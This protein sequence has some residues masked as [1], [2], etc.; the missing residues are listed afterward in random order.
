[1]RERETKVIKERDTK[2]QMVEK[3]KGDIS[4]NESLLAVSVRKV[5]MGLGVLPQ[6]LYSS[7]PSSTSST[8]SSWMCV[9]IGRV[10]EGKAGM[11]GKH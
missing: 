7:S 8:P 3:N 11:T 1:M 9:Y 10:L 2:K 5:R 6:A 4:L